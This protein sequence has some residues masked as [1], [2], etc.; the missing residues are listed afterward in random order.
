MKSSEDAR[1]RVL[2]ASLA[3]VAREGVRSLSFREVARLAGVS[4]QTPYHHFGSAHGILRALAAEGFSG[5]T[6][7]MSRAA[8]EA[9]QDPLDQLTAAGVA[10][11]GYANAHP[12]HF[13]V[14]FQG[15]GD[16]PLPEAR[17]TCATLER[18]TRAAH[19]GGYGAVVPV[20]VLVGVCWSVVHGVASLQA[21]GH[22]PA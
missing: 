1:R 17:G 20:G 9:G 3:L 14:M 7:A 19:A 12:G 15:P 21:E 2:D 5:L 22:R 11:V 4:H 16:E 13:R 8:T 18:L 10:Y 6:A